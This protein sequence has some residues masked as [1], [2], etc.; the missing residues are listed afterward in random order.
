MLASRDLALAKAP[1][2]DDRR[3]KALN[4]IR[5]T[6]ADV[7][8]MSPAQGETIFDF[9]LEHQ[10]KDCLELGFGH[11][12]SSCYIAGALRVLS[13]GKLTTVDIDAAKQREP[14]IEDLVRKLRLG[15]Y[16]NPIFEPQ[17]YTWFLM[18]AIERRRQFDFCFID[19]A[20]TWDTDGFAFFLVDRLLRPGGW[21][22]FD[23]LDWSY[24]VSPSLKDADWVKAKPEIE[25]KTKGVR[26]VF[27]LLVRRHA[28]YQTHELN[29]W[30]YAQKC[31]SSVPIRMLEVVQEN[32][33]QARKA[34]LN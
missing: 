14:R 22:V 26:K 12:V 27:D 15:R 5:E 3:L 2:V 8:H 18:R 16:V 17:S 13:Q 23:D 30:G 19:G 10:P 34:W 9:V 6:V 31:P 32:R 4:R 28:D 7:Q 33:L 25:Q 24:S 1:R 29:G 21:I 11:G 20:H